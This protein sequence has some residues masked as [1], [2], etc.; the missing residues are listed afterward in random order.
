[1]NEK[2]HEYR[3]CY[4]AMCV[5]FSCLVCGDIISL[6]YPDSYDEAEEQYNGLVKQHMHRHWGP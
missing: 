2:Q 5:Y 6:D 4:V 3:I 1:M